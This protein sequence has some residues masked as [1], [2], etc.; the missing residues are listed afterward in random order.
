VSTASDS[1]RKVLL[2]MEDMSGGIRNWSNFSGS[3]LDEGRYADAIKWFADTVPLRAY[4]S[5]L[6]ESYAS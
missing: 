2:C 1:S 3:T 4:K 6:R 5:T